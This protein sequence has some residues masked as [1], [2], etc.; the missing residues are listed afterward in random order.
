M[1]CDRPHASTLLCNDHT[2]P[3]LPLEA[4]TVPGSI[5]GQPQCVRGANQ[6]SVV[7]PST[8]QVSNETHQEPLGFLMRSQLYLQDRDAAFL[9]CS[10]R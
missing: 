1:V 6:A 4:G 9:I 3:I 8:S 10:C 2:L 5:S 7:P